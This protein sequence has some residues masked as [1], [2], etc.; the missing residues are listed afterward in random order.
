MLVGDVGNV[1]GFFIHTR[2]TDVR[3]RLGTGHVAVQVNELGGHD[4]TRTLLGVSQEAVDVGT[5]LGSGV[6]HDAAHHVGG[7]LLQHLGG[8]VQSHLLHDV[9]DLSVG[10]SRDDVLLGINI[11]L[12]KNVGSGILIQQLKDRGDTLIGQLVKE[13]GGVHG[14]QLFQLAAEVGIVAGVQQIFKVLKRPLHFLGT[15][16]GKDLFL[17]LNIRLNLLNRVLNGLLNR[18]LGD[19]SGS[20]GDGKL[21]TVGIGGGGLIRE[22]EGDLLCHV[23]GQGG[24]GLSGVVG[25]F[26]AGMIVG[27]RRRS[28]LLRASGG[29][30]IFALV[31]GQIKHVLRILFGITAGLVIAHMIILLALLIWNV[32]DGAGRHAGR[33]GVRLSLLSV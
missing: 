5:G 17:F 29:L 13:F 32:A 26:F 33:G 18:L 20:R 21:L 8:I 10:H 11:Q 31:S 4:A 19:G 24:V 25:L 28:K 16:L 7:Q 22:Q 2:G 14:V 6:L 1:Y 3:N 27:T 15:L 30:G 12:G 9:G 23:G